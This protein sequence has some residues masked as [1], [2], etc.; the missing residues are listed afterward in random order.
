MFAVTVTFE[1][2]SDQID[3]FLPLMKRQAETSL[4]E[5]EG[6]V[7]FDICRDGARPDVVFLYEIYADKAAFDSHLASAHFQEFDAA[8]RDLV[9]GK[10]IVCFDE[11]I[12]GT[13]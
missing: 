9:T 8:V 13:R 10:T 7:T 11:V 1:I 6:C 12:V 4:S 2:V 3:A 5:E